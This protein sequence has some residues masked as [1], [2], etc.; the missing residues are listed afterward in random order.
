MSFSILT[1]TTENSFIVSQI[2]VTEIVC[3]LKERTVFAY[4]LEIIVNRS[5]IYKKTFN[6]A[7]TL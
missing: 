5:F 2:K 3:E 4:W 7:S 6:L 1:V